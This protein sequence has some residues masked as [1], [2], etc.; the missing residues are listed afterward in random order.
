MFS[1]SPS[2]SLDDDESSDGGT[3]WKKLPAGG[4][5][6]IFK[7]QHVDFDGCDDDDVLDENDERQVIGGGALEKACVSFN[8]P[9]LPHRDKSKR[10]ACVIAMNFSFV[11]V[12]IVDKILL[13]TSYV[14][15]LR[16][17]LA[18]S[19][20]LEIIDSKFEDV[21]RISEKLSWLKFYFQG[22]LVE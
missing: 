2:F 4:L 18:N 11:M 10:P 15:S 13:S 8:K 7:E 1:S 19:E 22:F 6:A 12:V 21:K 16:I 20:L 14:S 5:S 9:P 3:S 17:I